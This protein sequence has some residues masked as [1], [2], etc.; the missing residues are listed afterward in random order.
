M[1]HAAHILR[2]GGV[3][4]NATEAVI[5]LAA[6]ADDKR[7]GK[8]IRHLKRRPQAK[9]FIVVV[10]HV[11]QL[12]KLVELRS[13]CR[14]LI[15]ASW[16]G[17]HTWVLPAAPR[18][19]KCLVSKTRDIAVR[20]TA[21]PQMS[22]LCRVVGPIV[23]TSANPAGRRPA[24]TMTAARGYFRARVDLYLAGAVGLSDRPSTIR[25]GRTGNLLR[26]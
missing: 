19:P 16:P 23:S 25:D 3:I 6:R 18:S 7:A 26:A 21:H 14:E 5:G 10:A 8:R 15:L 11:E 1:V 9:P 20:V 12:S 22:A 24:R 4:A 2:R 13:P 17:P